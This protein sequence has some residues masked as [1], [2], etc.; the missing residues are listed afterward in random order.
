MPFRICRLPVQLCSLCAPSSSS[1]SWNARA[2]GAGSVRFFLTERIGTWG[3]LPCTLVE[4]C[5]RG[6]NLTQLEIAYAFR[7]TF[8]VHAS[9]AIR[10]RSIDSPFLYTRTG[11]RVPILSSRRKCVS[12]KTRSDRTIRLSSRQ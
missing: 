10:L 3:K 4:P 8:S 6:A 2:R 7:P 12:S 11:F 1:S 9:E 5:E